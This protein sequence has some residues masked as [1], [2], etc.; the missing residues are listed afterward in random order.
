M[1]Y[2]QRVI[3][4]DMARMG[5]IGVADPRHVESYMRLQYATLDHLSR[6]DFRREIG[7]ALTCIEVEGTAV[8]EDCARSFGL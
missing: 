4:E 5:R 7:I 6:A 1:T 8:A 3:R 2:Y